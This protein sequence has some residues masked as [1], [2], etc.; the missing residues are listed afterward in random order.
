MLSQVEIDTGVFSAHLTRGA[1]TSKTKMAGVSL[2]D[3]VKGA[4]WGSV[5]TFS[6]WGVQLNYGHTSSPKCHKC[7]FL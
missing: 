7:Q 4:N 2:G 3:I 1:S 5:S 6:R